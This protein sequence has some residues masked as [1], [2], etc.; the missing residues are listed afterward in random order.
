MKRTKCA[1]LY[2][3]TFTS[4]PLRGP[5]S[6][7]KRSWVRG[8]QMRGKGQKLF[9]EK[10]NRSLMERSFSHCGAY[11]EDRQWSRWISGMQRI[12]QA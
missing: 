10:S 11:V 6:R 2:P 7:G 1:T 5:W 9:L 4:A 8:W 3:G 12:T